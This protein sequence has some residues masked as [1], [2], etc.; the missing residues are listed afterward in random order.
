MPAL[1][2]LATATPP[3]RVPQAE[4][5]RAAEGLLPPAPGRAG[6]LAVFENA[7]IEARDLAMPLEWYLQP[8]G[9][10]ERTAAY[11]ATGLRLVEEASRAA[12][13][14]AGLSARQVKGI[15]MVSTTGLATPSLDARLMNLL[16]FD[17]GTVRLPLWGL[18][19]AGGVAG[20][21]RGFELVAARGGPVLV[22]ALELCTLLFDSARAL[23]GAAGPDKKALVAA[24]LF[25][26]GCAAAVVGPGEDGLARHVASAS[27]LFPNTE[28]V[29][30]WDVEDHTLDVVLS[31]RIPDFVRQ[32][33]AATLAPL[34]ARHGRPDEWVLH[35][36]GA[37]VVDA[38]RDALD[39]DAHALR[40]TEAVLRRHGNMSSPTV[41]FALREAL[42][43]GGL[44]EGRTALLA[45]LGPGFASEAALLQG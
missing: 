15:V 17:P 6:L 2:S 25:G 12:L 30:G 14:E 5:R 40:H 38:Y 21:S 11:L 19:C 10:Q 24:S 4:L 33:A 35:P 29:M 22:V 36:G 27:H 31:P 32:S 1:L 26:D 42:A 28:R 18:G 13:S 23:A 16:P 39:L 41:L 44:R 37:K 9:F 3:N 7:R 43:A 8:H 20:L 34:L 45:A